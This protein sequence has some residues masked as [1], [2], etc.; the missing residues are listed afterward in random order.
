MSGYS[1]E[2]KRLAH[3]VAKRAAINLQRSGKSVT[4]SAV[5]GR[6]VV[7]STAA[8]NPRTS[9]TERKTG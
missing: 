3:E 4:R 5:T 8:R 2:S 1:K 9:V 7:S 6:Y